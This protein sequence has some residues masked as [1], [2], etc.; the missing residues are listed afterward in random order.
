MLKG[1]MCYASDIARKG[2]ERSSKGISINFVCNDF[3]F[4]LAVRPP[5]MNFACRF[6]CVCQKKGP[7]HVLAPGGTFFGTCSVFIMSLYKPARKDCIRNSLCGPF[8]SILLSLIV[9]SYEGLTYFNRQ[10]ARAFHRGGILLA[11]SAMFTC[12]LRVF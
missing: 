7:A 3:A 9:L 6:V 1:L 5:I 12:G 2:A 11:S 8:L 10:R 4:F